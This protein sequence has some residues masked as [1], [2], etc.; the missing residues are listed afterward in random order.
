MSTLKR[1]VVVVLLVGAGIATNTLLTHD[2]LA[3]AGR[4]GVGPGGAGGPG[5]PVAGVARRTTRRMVRRTSVYVATLPP[6]CKTVDID[7]TKVQQCGSTYY[8]ASGNQYEV[9]NIEEG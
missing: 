3:G 2:A 4:P 6:G 1:A 8:Q 7:G 9:V 5:R